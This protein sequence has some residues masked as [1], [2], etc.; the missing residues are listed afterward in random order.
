M[1]RVTGCPSIGL[2]ISYNFCEL[3]LYSASGFSISKNKYNFEKKL[4]NLMCSSNE[5]ILNL[6]D[7]ILP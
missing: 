1:L 7:T 6:W 2:G 5:R 3:F 4:W